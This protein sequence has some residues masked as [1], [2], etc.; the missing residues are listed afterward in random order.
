MRKTLLSVLVHFLFVFNFYSQTFEWAYGNGV[1]GGGPGY[2]KGCSIGTD[3]LG[4]VY[5]IGNH[6]GGVD[7]DPTSG[8][9]ILFHPSSS[10]QNVF[11]S[12]TDQHGHVLWVKE[13]TNPNDLWAMAM[14]VDSAGNI[15]S[16]GYMPASGGLSGDFDPG[17]A[18]YPLQTYSSYDIYIS[19]LDASGNFV[20][21]KS[22]YGIGK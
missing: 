17:P 9:N 3:A 4:N 15:Y 22:I 16:T 14:Y 19:K 6:S 18:V 7:M 10:N 8:L 21:A 1:S 2:S 13:L 12:K 11:I 5:T 20:W